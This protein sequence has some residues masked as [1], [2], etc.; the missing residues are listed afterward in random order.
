MLVVED[1][2]NKMKVH[3]PR[4]MDIRRKINSSTGGAVLESVALETQE[5]NLAIEDYVKDFFITNYVDAPESIISFI[6]RANV[7]IVNENTKLI[8]ISDNL[9]ITEDEKS[10]YEEQGKAF[11]KDGFIYVSKSYSDGLEIAIDGYK[12][13]VDLEK[14]H[15]WNVF[16]EFA[17][18][19]GL[20]RYQWES[21]T[22]LLNRIFAF[23]S[24]RANST[25]S[26][27]KHAIVSNLVN[28]AP[29][30]E[31]EDIVIERPTAEN[32]KRYYTEYET[33][34][35]YLSK[36]NRDVYS[37]KKW[38]IDVWN[39]DIKSID[40]IPHAWDVVLDSYQNGIGFD[41]DLEVSIVDSS[42][43]TD[44]MTYFYQKHLETCIAYI[45]NNNIKESMK[46]VLKKYEYDLKPETVK[47]KI[48]A[49]EA[50]IINANDIIIKSNE[51]KIGTFNV[52]IE[53]VIDP[54]FFN[55]EEID[56][57]I[58]DNAFNY[59]VEFIPSAPKA[60]FRIDYCKIENDLGE[61]INLL[62]FDRPGFS[63]IGSE[64]V[65]SSWVKKFVQDSYHFSKYDNAYKTIEGFTISDLSSPA[66]LSL[67]VNDCSNEEYYIDYTADEVTM[68][69]KDIKLNN[70]Y[71]KDGIIVA[72]TV[73]GDK[74]VSINKDVNSISLEI[75]GPYSLEY[76]IDGNT[77]VLESSNEYK[78]HLFKIDKRDTTFNLNL[79]VNLL[80][81]D[82]TVTLGNIKY[83]KYDFVIT[84]NKTLNEIILSEGVLP[85]FNE[86]ALNIYMRTYT[87]KSPVISSIY[88]GKLLTDDDSYNNV[89]I[90]TSIGTKLKTKHSGCVIKLTKVDKA[91]NN[92]LEIINNFKPY[93]SYKA[94]TNSAQLVLILDGYSEITNISTSVG[95]IETLSYG[96]DYVQ[97]VLKL[98]LGDEITDIQITGRTKFL[99]KEE[100]LENIL[101][102]KGYSSLNNM[103]YVSKAS[104]EIIAKSTITGKSDYITIERYDVLNEYNISSVDIES[105]GT[106]MPKFIERGQD[107]NKIET[108]T[109]SYDSYFDYISFFPTNGG[110]YTAINETRTV[111][112]YADRIKMVDTFNNGYEGAKS[113]CFFRIESLSDRK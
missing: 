20:T 83:S 110:I 112:P 58:L 64:G 17:V 79:I 66:N 103:F 15:V 98:S 8:I 78:K 75:N 76:S 35:D 105:N 108:N 52:N 28:I 50:E 99:I 27:L 55:I 2:L 88:I 109:E 85:N 51:N 41:G 60:D 113:K 18:F 107:G 102:E 19:L 106:I 12:H 93:T 86:N 16:D 22:E 5:I 71:I 53:D 95:E 10:F 59:K 73:A 63:I 67:K 65:K 82:N 92:D 1:I 42:E 80:N 25:E 104:D 72:D 24:G 54:F 48:T 11:Y 97:Y 26:G 29:D 21:N 30:L 45:Q 14:H 56:N 43:H 6:Y 31:L 87:G 37:E 4:W 96:G 3:F 46:L 32:L 9:E 90:D 101:N 40:Y 13:T 70:C 23:S 74:T 44:A 81:V 38:G 49:S 77:S 94:E 57:S 68:L 69:Y 89:I 7:G 84:T 62:E 91:T 39:F 100:S 111:F 47:Y 36:I 61:K 34:L 33:V